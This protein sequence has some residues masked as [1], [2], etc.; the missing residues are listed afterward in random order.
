MY[1]NCTVLCFIRYT[2]GPDLALIEPQT[3]SD[4]GSQ[5]LGYKEAWIDVP[6][7]SHHIQPQEKSIASYTHIFLLQVL[8]SLGSCQGCKRQYCHSCWV[9]YNTEE[10]ECRS[11]PILYIRMVKPTRA[12]YI[13]VHFTL[14]LSHTLH[15]LSHTQPLF[16]SALLV[17]FL[18]GFCLAG[19]FA[20]RLQLDVMP[21]IE[22]GTLVCRLA[23]RVPLYG[24]S[25]HTLPHTVLTHPGGILL[26][27]RSGPCDFCFFFFFYNK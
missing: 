10:C 12:F 18:Y 19:Y 4:S 20:D 22:A 2:K 16:S 11:W 8:C 6:K 26:R 7:V 15:F 21:G 14:Y 9:P 23:F 13:P 5:N 3:T 1:C 17:L 24:E 27:Q 25:L